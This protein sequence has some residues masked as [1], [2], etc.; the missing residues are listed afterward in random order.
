MQLA[1]LS[2]ATFTHLLRILASSLCMAQVICH[3]WCWLSHICAAVLWQ[4][5]HPLRLALH[6]A[7]SPALACKHQ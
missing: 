7:A 6:P 2:P 3:L 1:S 4:R 5:V